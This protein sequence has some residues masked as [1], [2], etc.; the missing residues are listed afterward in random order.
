MINIEQYLLKLPT[1]ILSLVA[2]LLASFSPPLILVVIAVCLVFADI[3]LG[4]IKQQ[5]MNSLLNKHKQL[6]QKVRKLEKEKQAA[7]KL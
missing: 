2:V 6:S 1:G 7:E 4:Y 5:A 3:T